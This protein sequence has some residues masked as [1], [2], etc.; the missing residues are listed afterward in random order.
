[1]AR[2]RITVDAYNDMKWLIK[3]TNEA[4]ADVLADQA[5][6]TFRDNI[7]R[8]YIPLYEEANKIEQPVRRRNAQNKLRGDMQKD[9]DNFFDRYERV[10]LNSLSNATVAAKRIQYRFIDRPA[11]VKETREDTGVKKISVKRLQQEEATR[12]LQLGKGTSTADPRRVK[13][14]HKGGRAHVIDK[15]GAGL[16]REAKKIGVTT[17]R[18][19]FT[20]FTGKWTKTVARTLAQGTIADADQ[21][22]IKESFK[23]F[24][25]V[26]IIDERTTTRCRDLNDKEFTADEA[27]AVRPPQHFNCR[28]ELQPVSSDRRRDNELSSKNK[29]RFRGWLSRQSK[30]TKRLVVGKENLKAYEEGRYEP[31]PRWKQL[32]KWAVDKETGLPVVPT[33]ANKKRIEVRTRLVDVEFDPDLYRDGLDI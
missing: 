19:Q 25:Y 2:E 13:Y 23:K 20:S 16:H 5:F 31:Q 4:T 8:K 3:L 27:N 1:M 15:L 6:D 7:Y 33:N 14:R 32:E 9:I 17:T 22:A 28:S 11:E 26:S 21:Q 24:R 12:E 18:S 30:E 10:T 29:E